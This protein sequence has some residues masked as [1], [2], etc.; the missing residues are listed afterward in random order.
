MTEQTMSVRRAAQLKWIAAAL[1]AFVAMC[2]PASAAKRIALVVGNAAYQTIPALA[3]PANDA[4]ATRDAL[5]QSGFEVVHVADAS[6]GAMRAT[7][8]VFSKKVEQA[9]ADVATVVF[10][11]GHAVQ[12][13]GTNYLLPIDVKLEKDSDIALQA[14]SLGDILKRLDATAARTKI[15]ILDACRN[16][17]FSDAGKARGLALQLVDGA[18]PPRD[19]EAGLARIES[20]GGTLVAFSTSPGA[21]AADGAD[22]HSPFATAFLKNMREPG[23]P[24]EQLF[25]RVRLAVHEAT[26]GAQTPW[27]TSSLTADF[28]FVDAPATGAKLPRIDEA[29][30]GVRPSRAAFEGKNGLQAYEKAILWDQPIG[31]RLFLEAYPDDP[32]ALRIM[33]MLTQRQ[34]ETAWAET[35]RAGDAESYQ[36]FLRLYPGS[37]HG[38]EADALALTSPK[39]ANLRSASVCIAPVPT[40]GMPEPQIRKT[41]A[42]PT[43]PAKKVQDQRVRKPKTAAVPPRGRRPVVEYEEDD[44]SP[45]PRPGFDPGA[46]MAIGVI[47]GAILGGGYGPSRGPRGSGRP[48][49][50][51]GPRYTPPRDGPRYTPPQPSTPRFTPNTS[52]YRSVN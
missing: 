9:G 18:A 3:N 20:K 8:E 43:A 30:A 24:V 16:N 49:M 40:R 27:E 41:N 14:V 29:A 47:G 31:Y 11:A 28:N 45:P 32:Q 35:V 34:E 19:E 37:A 6:L 23:L 5:E 36:L 33:R 51:D 22:N 4:R 10:Y 44:Y 25:R 13:A 15:V 21:T 46:A 17:P 26:G 7:L 50:S 39:R 2:E 38:A 1:V 42:K 48:P 12:L 52:T